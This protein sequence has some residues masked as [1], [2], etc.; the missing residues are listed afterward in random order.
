M[1]TLIKREIQ[2]HFVYFFGA[3]VSST[4][5]VLISIP[6]ILHYDSKE[7]EVYMIGIGLP[8][9]IILIVAFCAIGAS[10]MYGDRTRKI[11]AFLSTQPTSRNKILLARIITGTLAIL[12]FFLPLIIST[13]IL[14][15]LSTPPIPIYSGM[16][17]EISTATFLMAYACYCIGLQAG[18]SMNRITPTL[19]GLALSAILVPLII[20]KGFGLEISVILLLFII[21]SLIRIRQTFISTSL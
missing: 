17:F 8:A 2:D 20:I 7:K 1:F 6:T 14:I 19:G 18:W 15:R 16:I 9:V 3:V 4:L 5:I 13:S 12:I 10:Q 11:S 21:A